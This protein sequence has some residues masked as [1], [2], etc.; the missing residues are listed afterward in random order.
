MTPLEVLVYIWGPIWLAI[1]I[2]AIFLTRE[3]NALEAE[4]RENPSAE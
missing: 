1:G 2:Y 4:S 3:L